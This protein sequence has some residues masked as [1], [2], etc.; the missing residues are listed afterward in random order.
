MLLRRN[1]EARVAMEKKVTQYWYRI[2]KLFAIFSALVEQVKWLWKDCS[3]LQDTA[4]WQ[5]FFSCREKLVQS[6]STLIW[7]SESV[8]HSWD[9]GRWYCCS[10]RCP[11]DPKDWLTFFPSPFSLQTV[12]HSSV[13]SSNVLRKM[14]F[15]MN[16]GCVQLPCYFC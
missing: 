4:Q 14:L 11:T 10:F 5:G 8:S 1:P 2:Y 6:W 15:S 7:L 12:L 9:R 13:P 3:I 16:V